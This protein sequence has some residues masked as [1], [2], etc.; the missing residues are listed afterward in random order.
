MAESLLEALWDVT[1]PV[2]RPSSRKKSIPRAH[3]LS[4]LLFTL[5]KSKEIL[6]TTSARSELSGKRFSVHPWPIYTQINVSEKFLSHHRSPLHYSTP[7]FYL[8]EM[9]QPASPT[10]ENNNP[11]CSKP[12]AT[13]WIHPVTKQASERNIHKSFDSHITLKSVVFWNS[14]NPSAPKRS[15]QHF[16][17]WIFRGAEHRGIHYWDQLKKQKMTLG[18]ILDAG[19]I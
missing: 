17:H 5:A 4:T 6:N 1:A 10:L 7:T 14:D 16:G 11:P 3:W 8:Q 15:I 12:I 13:A 9:S 18:K 19:S 2:L